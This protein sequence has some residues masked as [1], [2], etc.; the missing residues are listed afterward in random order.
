MPRFFFDIDDGSTLVRDGD[1]TELADRGA[2]RK[3]TI[4]AL[5]AIAKEGLP[6]G[7]R[8]T[9]VAKVR[10]RE[11]RAVFMASLTLVAEWLG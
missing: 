7:D 1:G 6:D 2:V 4:C 10:D 9:F 3:E 5:V 8:H 11:G